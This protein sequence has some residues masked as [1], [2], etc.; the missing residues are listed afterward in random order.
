MTHTISGGLQVLCV[1]SECYPLL[2]TGGLAD[3]VGALPPALKTLGVNVTL[4]LPGYPAILKGFKGQ[5]PLVDI[6]SQGHGPARLL[7]GTMPGGLPVIV[8]DAPA[9]FDVTG[10]PY[11]DDKGLDRSDNAARFSVFSRTAAALAAG[12]LV[13]DFSCQILHAHD[14][15]AGL[16]CAYLKAMEASSVKSV[17]TVHNLAFQGLFP[18]SVMAI[19]E[20]PQSFYSREGL[21]YWDQVS[22]MK[23]GLVYAD[24]VT[25]VSPTYALEIQSDEGGMGMGGLLRARSEHLSGI[26]NGIDT[27]VWDP[28]TDGHIPFHYS[29]RARAGKARN[30][31]ALQDRFGM[32]AAPDVP[33]F[34]VISRLTTQKGL[35]V[36][37][38]L[39]DHIVLSGGQ[40]AVLGSGDRAIEMAFRQARDRHPSEI[41]LKIGYDE[42]LAHHIQAGAD[43]IIIPSRFEP[44]GLTQLYA[45]RYGTVPVAGRVGGLNDTIIDANP[46]ALSKAA[47]T[48]IL[49]HPI[50]HH[51]LAMAL[52][53]AF[54]LYRDKKIWKQ[55][56][57][58][59]MKQSVGWALSAK[60]YKD[61]F[62]DVIGKTVSER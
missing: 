35:D 62:T 50:N 9:L 59:A 46:A 58:N 32:R 17:F 1:A 16:C 36:L 6:D 30:K 34:C 11:L 54:M 48:G 22:F 7:M 10:N 53:R 24:H 52:D 26:L 20:L 60:A 25:T 12:R 56:L 57:G 39:A 55:M 27:N 4:F 42:P 37:A 19:T 23:A 33:L 5:K 38:D 40:L 31:K 44:C 28:Q 47:A 13:A 41:G 45:M 14:W 2:K 29:P 3:V 8:L 18:K 51:T 49:F 43:A 61:L 15:Q 21:E